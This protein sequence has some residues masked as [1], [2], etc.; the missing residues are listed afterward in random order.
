MSWEQSSYPVV[1]EVVSL[2]QL[3][4]SRVNLEVVE[5]VNAFD[6]TEAV[7]QNACELEA[8]PR[9]EDLT[10]RSFNNNLRTMKQ[11][12]RFIRMFYLGLDLFKPSEHHFYS[13]NYRSCCHDF[14]V[15]TSTSV[16]KLI[17]VAMVTPGGV[18]SL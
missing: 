10:Q 3:L 15:P 8:E 1:S 7:V 18:S 16:L 13:I 5:D 2:R 17:P 4:D 6:V 14:L 12:Y 11:L 9:G